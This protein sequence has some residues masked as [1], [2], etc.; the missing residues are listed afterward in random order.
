MSQSLVPR[1]VS[2][3]EA[4]NLFCLRCQAERFQPSTL[5]FYGWT[6]QPFFAWYE[7]Q[8]VTELGDITAHPIRTYFHT[9]AGC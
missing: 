1:F 7:A 4:Y 6:L 8:H 3:S 9:A 5:R 2:I